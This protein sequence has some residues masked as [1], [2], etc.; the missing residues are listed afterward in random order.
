MAPPSDR[1]PPL[2]MI[3]GAAGLLPPLALVLMMLGQPGALAVPVLYAVTLVY[4]ALILSFIGGA[5][6]GFAAG[7]QRAGAGVLTLAVAPT[8]VAL[9]LLLLTARYPWA[10][11]LGLAAVVA[12]S[13]LVDL[14]MRRWE[15]APSWW[16]K[17]RVPLSLALGTLLATAAL[18]AV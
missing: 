2:F 17:L 4:G 9:S 10:G 16:L 7:T 14:Q 3:F 18:I 11:G 13:P 6:W 1:I 5:W 12:A 8:L 15:L